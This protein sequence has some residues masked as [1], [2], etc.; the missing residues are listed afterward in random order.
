M[1]LCSLQALQHRE[2]ALQQHLSQLQKTLQDKAQEQ[3][4][5]ARAHA[6]EKQ[7]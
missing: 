2:A 7:V 6:L 4:Q 3:L 1:C 5:Q